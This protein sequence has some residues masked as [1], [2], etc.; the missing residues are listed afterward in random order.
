MSDDTAF[1]EVLA[2]C[3][4]AASTMDLSDDGFNPPDGT[5]DVEIT[6]VDVGTK[7]KEG[8]D[9]AWVKP[10]FTILDGDFEGQNFTNFFWIPGVFDAD[11]PPMGLKRLLQFASCLAGMEVR[12]PIEAIEVSTAAIGEYLNI[13]MYTTVA[14]KTK[15]KYHNTRFLRRLPTAE[16]TITPEDIAETAVTEASVG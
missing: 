5:Y 2:A 9:N 14:K 3:T 6:G 7:A 16:G 4:E 15:K 1:L 11:K 12:N 8:V 10:T 13:E